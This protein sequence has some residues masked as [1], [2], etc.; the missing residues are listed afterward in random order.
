[1]GITKENPSSDFTHLKVVMFFENEESFLLVDPLIQ[2]IRYVPM[3][4][5]PTS[6]QGKDLPSF[7]K[8]VPISLHLLN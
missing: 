3:V 5:S 1:V 7:C 8:Q 4:K 6:F 2:R